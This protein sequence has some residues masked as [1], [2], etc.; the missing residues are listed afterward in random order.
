MSSD[1]PTDCETCG[2]TGIRPEATVNACQGVFG[3]GGA[4]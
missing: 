1:A 2:G 4:V 3:F